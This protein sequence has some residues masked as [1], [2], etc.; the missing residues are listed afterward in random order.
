M[1]MESRVVIGLLTGHNT[2]RRHLHIMGLRVSA[3]CRKCGAEEETSAVVLCE[4]EVLATH[5]HTY[6][7]SF[8]FDPEDVREISLGAIW[9]FIKATGLS[10]HGLQLRGT[11]GLLKPYVL[12][13]RKDPT[14]YSL[15]THTPCGWT[16]DRR[17]DG[18]DE[19][20]SRYSQFCE[21]A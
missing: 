17:T 4:C 12:R 13:D 2:F 3:L 14:L 7:G 16:E 18:H 8:C 1:R 10:W 20:N 9:N 19:A 5:R 11:K 21:D 15:I 6:L